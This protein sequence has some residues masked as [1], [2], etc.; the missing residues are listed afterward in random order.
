MAKCFY[1]VYVDYIDR[2]EEVR[3][4]MFW[5]DRLY[6]LTQQIDRWKQSCSDDDKFRVTDISKVNIQQVDET[7]TPVCRTYANRSTR[8]E[9]GADA[10]IITTFNNRY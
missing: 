8:Q 7:P 4:K 6:D 2:G 3:T 10:D 1:R 9:G 5:S